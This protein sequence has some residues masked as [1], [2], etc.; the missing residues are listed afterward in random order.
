MI[1]TY[2]MTVFVVSLLAAPVRAQETPPTPPLPLPLD[3]PAAVSSPIPEITTALPAAEESA[4][5]PPQPAAPFGPYTGSTNPPI[6]APDRPSN[7]VPDFGGLLTQK[8]LDLAARFGW[9]DVYNR[10]SPVKTG[11][12]QSLRPS[13]FMDLDGLWTDGRRTINFFADYLDN[14]ANQAAM[15]VYGP[16]GWAKMDFQRYIRELDHIPLTYVIDQNFINPTVFTTRGIQSN[17]PVTTNPTPVLVQDISVGQDYAYR[18]EQARGEVAENLTD[19]IQLRA[20]FFQLR[21]FGERQA[22]AM[23]RC[24]HPPEFGTTGSLANIRACHILSQR[25]IVDWN[26][27]EITPK[28]EGRWGPLSIEYSH[29]FRF[30]NQNDQVVTRL[31]NGTGTGLIQGNLPYAV[32]PESTTNFD[33]LRL[34]LDITDHTRLYAFGYAGNTVNDTR[35]VR[36]DYLGYDIRLTDHTFKQLSLTAYTRGYHQNGTRPDTFLPEEAAGITETGPNGNTIRVA[37]A[38]AIRD[39]LEYHRTTA[40]INSRWV[41][42][43]G[44]GMFRRTAFISGYEYEILNREGA[45]FETIF[46]KDRANTLGIVEFNQPSTITNQL[47]GGIQQP[48]TNTFSTQLMYKIFYIHE[49][50]HG[51]REISGYVNSNLPEERQV[52]ELME[53]WTPRPTLG[54]LFQQDVDFRKHHDDVGPVIPQNAID[55]HEDNYSFVNS[56]WYAPTPKW[57]LSASASWLSNWINQIINLGDE[58]VDPNQPPPPPG[59]TVPTDSKRWYYGGRAAVLGSRADYKV[60]EGLWLHG[61]Y[62]WVRGEDLIDTRNL[63]LIGAGRPGAVPW[64]DLPLYSHVLVVTQRITAGVDWKPREHFTAYLRYIYY[65]YDDKAMFFNSGTSHMALAGCTYKW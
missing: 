12:W 61:G 25:Q 21:K 56:V 29:M 60:C 58:Y 54:F 33:Q 20:Q 39:P 1:R 49:P 42:G 62:E 7:E 43:W 10:G 19:N 27:T 34:G 65:D 6:P 45:G 28:V 26:T 4:P 51:F 17:R 9:W 52:V 23:A 46:L 38:D 16:N 14:E 24:F 18:I 13:P 59:G 8:P 41:P 35:D 63:Q 3:P 30:F 22:N 15:Q 48:W 40:G 2:A 44:E 31:E 55:F 37:G 47:Y 64:T 11:E 36:R 50:L 57:V 32:V 5:P 53:S